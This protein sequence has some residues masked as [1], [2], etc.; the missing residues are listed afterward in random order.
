MGSALLVIG[1]FSRATHLSVKTL[2]HYHDVGLLEPA[3]V[4]LETGYRRYTVGQ[5]QQAQI[6]RRFRDLEMPLEEI[7]AVL[8]APDLRTRDSLIA[9]HLTRMEAALARTQQ[10][11]ASLRELLDCGTR[12]AE[13]GLRRV[14]ATP[15]AAISEVIDVASALAWYQGALGELHG[16]LA[17]Q[18]L[19]AAGP[20]GGLYSTELFAEGRGKATVF[21]PCEDAVE[22]M[23]RVASETVPPVD[24]ATLVHSGPHTDIDRSYGALAA[25]VAA[26]EMTMD[27]PVREYYLV[28]P[29][30]TADDTAWRTEIG[31]PVFITGAGA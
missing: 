7:H 9:A 27:G 30:G 11:V 16:T 4:D 6:I 28:G 20:S 1:D 13:V 2:R 5:I 10:A 12:P 22:A 21:V 23:G 26:H 17:A 18:G 19:H 15:V 8:A 29:G 3:E 25:H 31:W 24:L 14:T